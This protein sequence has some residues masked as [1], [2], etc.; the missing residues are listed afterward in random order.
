M[1][2][3]ARSPDVMAPA[4]VSAPMPVASLPVQGQ[5]VMDL[6]RQG[7]PF[8]Y[9]KDG[10]VFGN[11]ERLLPG[12]KH[13]YYREYTVPTPGLSHRGARRIVCGGFKPRWPEA[14]YYTEDHYGS[15]RLVVQ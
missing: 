5:A 2:V 13:G 1:V 7:G 15:F 12:Q 4:V 9:E 6:I 11:R 10:T 3:Q 8:R 14:C